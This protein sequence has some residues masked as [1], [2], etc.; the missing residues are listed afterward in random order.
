MNMTPACSPAAALPEVKVQLNA[1][2]SHGEE[3]C[4]SRGGPKKYME[5]FVKLAYLRP[6]DTYR[7]TRVEPRKPF[8][9]QADGSG[10][11]T[12]EVGV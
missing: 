3:Y 12:A 11:G 5:P 8:R 10:A 4:T 9:P 1:W 6:T 7:R 2:L